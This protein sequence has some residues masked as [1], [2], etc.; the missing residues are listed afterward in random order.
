MRNALF[1]CYTKHKDLRFMRFYKII[2]LIISKIESRR[3]SGLLSLSIFLV[4]SLV[5]S[6]SLRAQWIQLAPNLLGAQST[7]MG[8]IAH[9]AGITWAGSHAVFMSLDS[10]ISWTQRWTAPLGKDNID[11]IIFYDTQIGLVCTH[12]GTVYR[13]DDQ[14]LSWRIIHNLGAYSAAFIGSSD[15]IIVA[16]GSCAACATT[17]VTHDGGLTWTPHIHGDWVPQVKALLGGSAMAIA[18]TYTGGNTIIRTNDY[19]D[20]WQPL[21]GKFD[22]DSYSFEVDPCDPNYIFVV[23]EE[24]TTVIDNKGAIYISVDGGNTFT[25]TQNSPVKFFCGSIARTTK[26]L[27]IQTV[28]NGINRSTD[29][30]TSW[31]SIGGPSAPFDTRLLCAI[32]SN[33]VLAADNNGTIWRTLNSGGDSLL[34]ISPYESL[35]ISPDEIFEKDTLVSCDSP[36]VGVFY[37]K[38]ILC[39]YPKILAQKISGI[40]SADYRIVQQLGD[41]ISGNDSILVSFRPHGSGARKGY[42]SITLEDGTQILLPLKGFGRDI[43]FVEPQTANISVDTIGGFAEVPIRFLGFPQKEDIEVVIHYDP[44]M[45]YNNSISLSGTSLD[46]PGDSSSGR[47]K[48]RIPKNEMSLDTVTGIAIFTVFPDNDDCYNVS[49]DS[50]TILSPSAP[51]TYSIGSPVSAVVCPLRGCGV[52]TLTNYMLHGVTPQLFVQPNPNHGKVLL[53]S[54]ITLSDASVE[55]VDMLG[56]IFAKKNILLKKGVASTLELDNLRDGNYII[57]ISAQEMQFQ[58]PILIIR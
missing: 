10:G 22:F 25:L 5:V 58:M 18:G 43:V 21:L 16:T 54:T 23:N 6:G 37:L 52:M 14:G 44:R 2:C 41:S 46:I 55:V 32:N 34:N 19:G 17:E 40:D 38:G 26:A 31:N 29:R 24:G 15:N 13:T 47:A 33:I 30:G 4:I 39:K 20:T 9:K 42:Y 11:D 12:M 36:V 3:R 45:I 8:A 50:M 51:C 27:F 28:T 35:A 7:E 53:T 48:I 57:K 1:H 49:F 56:R